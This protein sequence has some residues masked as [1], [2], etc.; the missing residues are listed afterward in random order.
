[1][2]DVWLRRATRGPVLLRLH[3]CARPPGVLAAHRRPRRRR[4]RPRAQRRGLPRARL[5]GRAV[6][7]P[8]LNVR[9]PRVTREL[10]HVPLPPPRRG[11]RGGARGRLPRR[12]VPVAERQRR[13]ARRPSVV[14]LNPL[15][16]RW[17]PDLSHN[18]RHVN[19]AIF[20]NVWQL[21]PGDRRPASS[22]AT[23]APR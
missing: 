8:F 11:A 14:H 4:A 12:H 7:L 15:S 23:T 22:C 10:L 16:G 18:Q 19:A 1:M 6:R 5:L 17:E 20:Y 21:L 3:I 13:P 2:C 9:L